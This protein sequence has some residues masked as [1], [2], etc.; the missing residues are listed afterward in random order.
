VDAVGLSILQSRLDFVTEEMGIV[1]RRSA[2][3]PIFA[4]S[5]DFSCFVSDPAGFVVS[6]ADGLPMHTASGGYAIRRC[7]EY[8]KGQISDGDLYLLNDPYFAAGNHLPDW[9]AIMPVFAG[10][11]LIG[12][13]CTRAHQI[14][15]G[16]GYPGTYNS[17]AKEIFEEG[18]RL[19]PLALYER[20]EPRQ[21]IHDLLL[22]NTRMPETVSGDLGAMVGA[23]RIGGRR[24]VSLAEDVGVPA[25]LEA[26]G[27]LL[28]YGEEIMRRHVERVP[29]GRYH[30]EVEMNN[31]CF[32]RTEVKIAIAVEVDGSDISVDFAGTAPQVRG[33]KNSPIFNTTAAACFGL[34][35]V[36]CPFAPMNEGVYRMMSVT[37]PEG[38]VVNPRPPA[39][40]TLC[41]SVPANEIIQ[42]CWKALADVMLDDVSAGWG[43]PTFPLSSGV[44]DAGDDYVMYHWGGMGG[45]GA[46]RHRDGINQVGILS[47]LGLLRVPSLE[48]YEQLY[49]VRFLSH[50]YRRD[51]GGAGERRGGT[52][53]RYELEV[54]GVT[55][56]SFRGEGLY[57]ATGFGVGGGGWGR[58]AVIE[59]AGLDGEPI[60]IPQYGVRE[61]PPMRFRLDS[62]GGG[63]W[64][65]PY[66]RDPE[67]VAADVRDGL[68]SVQ[69]AR[70]LYRVVVREPELVVDAA[71][72]EDL[73]LLTYG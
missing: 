18:L 19:P 6:Y 58:E 2:A 49:P 13:S 64:G 10:G 57:D 20:G 29:D 51:G 41:T 67:L 65:D 43:T 69:A 17:S 56:W 71:A 27:A 15:I 40:C 37:A 31:D 50:E 53:V 42:G 9:T 25:L 70:E 61:L 7:I 1:M 24:I 59:A 47:T 30:A 34:R 16:G 39:A 72:T 62:P 45:A 23:C 21:D 38:S 28:D 73:R 66:A 54:E 63:G 3:S 55:R 12:F 33:F 36:I 44:T 32:E 4:E 5:H 68:V 11:T 14:D 48:L 35:S 60:E 26:W 22:L 46:T 8:R 52:G